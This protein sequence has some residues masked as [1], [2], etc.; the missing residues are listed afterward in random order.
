MLKT[1]KA[2]YRNG[3]FEP[4]KKANLIDGT[5][6]Y[7]AFDSDS[8]EPED[9]KLR[10]FLLSAGSWKDYLDESFLDEIFEQRK[11]K[12]REEANL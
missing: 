5:E 8:S 2:K 3:V 10:L 11:R 9:E 6:V 7:I 4:L 1:I 12:H